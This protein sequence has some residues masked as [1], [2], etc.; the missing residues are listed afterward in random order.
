MNFP[1]SLPPAVTENA[2]DYLVFIG[3]TCIALLLLARRRWIAG[4]IAFLLGLVWVLFYDSA[5]DYINDLGVDSFA[6]AK[7]FGF[8]EARFWLKT[9]NSQLHAQFVVGQLL[10]YLA[11][12]IAT[13][14]LLRWLL[15]RFE[16]TARNYAFLKFAVASL[17]IVAGIHQTVYRSLSLFFANSQEFFATSR[18][19]TNPIPHLLSDGQPVTIVVYIG[20]STSALN[21]GLY[22]YPRETTPHLSALAQTD[23][24]LLVFRDVFSTHTHTSQSLLEALSFGIDAEENWLP[25]N[26]RRRLSIVD[27]L[28][29]NRLPVWLYSTQGM[30]GTWNQ[31]ST[32]VF[33]RAKALYAVDTHASGDRDYD[34]DRPFD[35][36]FFAQHVP[37]IVEKPSR[38]KRLVF[39]HSYAGHGPYLH[40]LPERFQK[41]V[42]P[43]FGPTVHSSASGDIENVED[44]RKEIEGYDS[45]ITYVDFSVSQAIAMARAAPSP[46]IVLYFSDHGDSVF[47][48][49]G[50]DSARFKHEMARVP[51]LLYFNPAAARARPDLVKKY[52]AL[53]QLKNTTTLAQVPSTVLDLM[54]L[55]VVEAPRLRVLL[56]P[57]IG[58]KTVQPPIIV[59]RTSDGITFVNVN[60]RTLRPPKR[61]NEKFIDNT[62][63]ETKLYA[64]NANRPPGTPGHC[65]EVGDS[66]VR[67]MRSHLIAD[68][69]IA[70]PDA[71]VPG[72]SPLPTSQPP[73]ASADADRS[74]A[75]PPQAH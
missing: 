5:V 31:A 26:E 32:I 34:V 41:P 30:T 45:A 39:F 33:K 4:Q 50:H 73:G 38:D 19:F 60:P 43:W 3:T 35:H 66:F 27:V 65:Y 16:F 69:V 68:C 58:E 12:A 46:T 23:P 1:P 13:F 48:N 59:R 36:D 53:A 21:M 11:A 10:I 15:N 70:Q 25:I 56:T 47:T 28:A 17:I 64:F 7:S 37:A 18:N 57:L 22:G 67:R 9:M 52:R 29:A 72:P 6:E 62:D 55:K 49:E 2:G 61:F 24:G 44:L 14:F 63:P 8:D 20:E 51:F 54:G 74:K 75:T 42:D 40:W 71:S